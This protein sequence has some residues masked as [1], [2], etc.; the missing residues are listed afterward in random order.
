MFVNPVVEGLKK[1][2]QQTLNSLG[3]QVRKRNKDVNFDDGYSEQARLLGAQNVTVV[4]DVGAANGRN[5]IGYS[6]LFPRANVYSF[7]PFPSHF[8]ELLETSKTN[9]RIFPVNVAI[10][11]KSGTAT[12]YCTEGRDSNSLLKP[13]EDTGSTFDRYHKLR[14][15]VEVKTAT[16]D[17]VCE[18]RAIS[19]VDV[20]KMDIQGAE[21][22][23]LKGA[24][25][26]LSTGAIDLIYSEIQ[27][28]H[29]YEGSPL[30][31]DLAMH[32]E[33]F[34]YELFNI[35][36]LSHNQRGQLA[37]GDAIFLKKA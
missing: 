26:M 8:A 22:A 2:S 9:S 27:F 17:D 10:S 21:L 31:H 35:Y 16:I 11:D 36:N 25:R 3:Y 33:R 6:Q 37:W 20:L 5:S 12:F 29:L 7:E 13:V 23:A 24:H 14:E 1:Y 4:F 28:I 19:R 18:E 15:A 30:F 34:G 32:L